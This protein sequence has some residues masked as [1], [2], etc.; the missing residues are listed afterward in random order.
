MNQRGIVF[1]QVLL[2][3]LITISGLAVTST[4]HK[5]LE[6]EKHKEAIEKSSQN[7][8]LDLIS[9]Q[10]STP[11][12]TPTQIPAATRTPAILPKKITTPLPSDPIVKCKSKYGETK[13]IRKSECDQMVDCQVGSSWIT[14]K[15]D[16][17]LKIQGQ[18]SVQNQQQGDTVD[19]QIQS[20]W[21]KIKEED[22]KKAQEIWKNQI[23]DQ[24]KK[25]LHEKNLRDM[26]QFLQ[27][28]ELTREQIDAELYKFDQQMK[29][30]GL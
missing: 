27:Q 1:I 30:Q 28:Q 2:W 23:N 25:D 14:L 6:K 17:C 22:C 16:E 15:R 8:I 13:E 24:V 12:A 18:Q 26:E 11:S 3:T 5:E 20:G 21:V 9:S 19:C 7:K 4:I 29:A 10:T